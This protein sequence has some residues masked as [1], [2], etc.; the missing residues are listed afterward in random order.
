MDIQQYIQRLETNTAGL[1]SLIREIPEAHLHRAPAESWTVLQIAE[2]ICK[3]DKLIGILLL[4]PTNDRKDPNELLGNDRL[5]R[6]VVDMRSRK[7][8]APDS[9]VPKGIFKSRE[10]F[11]E[12]FLKQRSSLKE[13][14]LKGEIKI[15]NRY[16]QHPYLGEM[17][18]PDWLYFILH[19]TDRHREQIKDLMSSY[20]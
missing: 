8:K 19:H 13:M 14:L 3:T 18:I 6:L 16:Y 15:D 7:V 17:L 9:L 2:H 11:E 4:N 12:R 1:L 20:Q 5:K 10:E